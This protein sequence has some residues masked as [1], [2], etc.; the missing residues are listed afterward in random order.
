MEY[1]DPNVYGITVKHYL[2]FIYITFKVHTSFENIT[3][4]IMLADM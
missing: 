2:C 3:L 4:R 1:F